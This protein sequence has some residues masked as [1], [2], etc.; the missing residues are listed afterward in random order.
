M[1]FTRISYPVW[2]LGTVPS[3]PKGRMPLSETNG[4]IGIVLKRP[5]LSLLVS[6]SVLFQAFCESRYQLQY[7]SRGLGIFCKVLVVFLLSKVSVSV[8][9]PGHF[10]GI[11][12]SMG[13]KFKPILSISLGIDLEPAKVSVSINIISKFLILSVSGLLRPCKRYVCD[14]DSSACV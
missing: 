14:K 11:S 9:V 12:I 7:R 5:I 8:S 4:N 1:N 3:R 10:P 2:I 13:L 6:V